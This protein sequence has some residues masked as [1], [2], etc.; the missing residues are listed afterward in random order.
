MQNLQQYSGLW[1]FFLLFFSHY[2]HQKTKRPASKLQFF[3]AIS[4]LKRFSNLAQ[5][6]AHSKMFN[7]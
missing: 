3:A 4:I 5:A 6:S 1:T 2:F 7:A